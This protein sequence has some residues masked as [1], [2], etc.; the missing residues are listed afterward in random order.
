ML[1]RQHRGRHEHG[2]LF[3]AHHRL[4]RRADRDLRFAEAD[5]AADQAVHR[6]RQLHVVF[7][8]GDRGELVG[9]FAEGKGMLE[10]ALPF[11]VGR[12]TRGRAASRARPARPAFC[13]RNR[14]STPPRFSSRAPI[15]RPPSELSGG[16]FFP[17]PDVAR[18]E[19]G[20]L[21]RD[22]EPGVVGELERERFL[23][24]AAGRG[25]RV[26][27]RKR[28]MPCSRWTTRSP[29]LSSLKSIWARLRL[30]RSARCRR[31]R[32]CAV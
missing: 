13:R 26:S 10:F 11:G 8:R 31:R 2:D 6:P 30:S 17:T 16:D 24:F 21:Q 20:L 22:V 4:E 14:R 9:R 5:V 18:D 32:P 7:G 1:L 27:C 12:Q 25:T 15:S 19:I 3:S 23:H 28:P 29:S